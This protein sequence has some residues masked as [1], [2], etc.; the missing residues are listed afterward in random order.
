MSVGASLAK[1]QCA[2]SVSAAVNAP[3]A[4]SRMSDHPLTAL[5]NVGLHVT[6]TSGKMQYASRPLA[7]VP[8]AQSP[9]SSSLS[10]LS[11]GPDRPGAQ[12]PLN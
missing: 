2:A 8:T 9:H 5:S 4:G 11:T 1:S 3:N 12:P 10:A 7:K 6:S